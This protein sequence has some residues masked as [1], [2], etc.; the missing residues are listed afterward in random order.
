MESGAPN[1]VRFRGHDA[2]HVAPQAPGI[3]PSAGQRH[4]SPPTSQVFSGLGVGLQGLSSD[5]PARISA[6]LVRHQH[7]NILLRHRADGVVS[8][9]R[10]VS[11]PA[12]GRP[13][14]PRGRWLPSVVY[15]RRGV[16]YL[17]GPRVPRWRRSLHLLWRTLKR[18]SPGRI[19]VR[20]GREPMGSGFS[21]RCASAQVGLGAES[22]AGGQRLSRPIH[23]KYRKPGLPQDAGCLS[24]A[25]LHSRG[26]AVV[27]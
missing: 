21:S 27:R 6:L 14:Q 11:L 16:H 8:P 20:A 17:Y 13:V 15:P 18:L 5:A 3:A 25:L 9:G 26:M 10:Q 19:W 22:T 12:S 2:L 4:R 1:P 7:A 24:V 23:V